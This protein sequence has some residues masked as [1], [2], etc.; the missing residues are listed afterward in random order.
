MMD[1]HHNGEQEHR[2]DDH[3]RDDS[4]RFRDHDEQ[5]FTQRSFAEPRGI[6]RL[7]RGRERFP[8][9][10][11]WRTSP[12]RDERLGMSR[13]E[14]E[15]GRHGGWP[16]EEYDPDR[17]RD[18]FGDAPF[19]GDW[20]REGRSREGTSFRDGG[21]FAGGRHQEPR[22]LGDRRD[23]EDRRGFDERQGRAFASREQ[24]TFRGRSRDDARWGESSQHREPERDLYGSGAIYGAG[25]GHRSQQGW[26][27]QHGWGRDIA[28]DLDVTSDPY[29][30]RF[31]GR[32]P[33]SYQRG[34]ERVREDVCDRLTADPRVDASNITVGVQGGEVTLEGTVDDRAMKRRAEDTAEEVGGVRQVHNRL[35]VQTQNRSDE[36][37]QPFQW[38]GERGWRGWEPASGR[39]GFATRERGFEPG[40]QAGREQRFERSYPEYE[41][42]AQRA[43]EHGSYGQPGRH[44][45]RSRDEQRG[46][47]LGEEP[48]RY[49]NRGPKG[50]QRS[51]DR[52]REDVCDRL[53]ADASV[54][55]TNI[56]VMVK[57][58]EVTIEGSVDDRNMKRHAEDCADGVSGVR[59]VHNRLVVQPQHDGGTSAG[60]KEPATSIGTSAA[61]GS[62]TS[63]MAAGGTSS[64]S[65][66]STGAS[67]RGSKG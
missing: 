41:P 62:P 12:D 63:G 50:Y 43:G 21:S 19:G 9:D 54:D 34:D 56:T 16:R 18:R 51:D 24:D 59:Q 22:G 33:K 15:H 49:G 27:D 53:T 52:I 46:A 60:R 38:G 23:Q 6:D 28:R 31:A 45:D 58:G 30:G 42:M 40:G 20:H 32:G 44:G 67:S 10:E 36:E 3:L 17:G 65:T 55:A 29:A 11:Q 4:R 64:V 7:A 14:P 26:R 57:D 5:D 66:A 61:S 39:G 1:R 8:E 47:W 13:Y 2:R 35:T 25:G 48:G 37:M